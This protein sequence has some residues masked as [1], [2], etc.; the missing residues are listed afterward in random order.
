MKSSK[1]QLQNEINGLKT[2]FEQIKNNF[3]DINKQSNQTLKDLLK[4]T[5][6][7]LESKIEQIKG[8]LKNLESDVQI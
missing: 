8:N 1:V 3:N 5:A 4:D 6:V 7:E 2:S